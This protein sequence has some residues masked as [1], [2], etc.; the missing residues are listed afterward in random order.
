MRVVAYYWLSTNPQDSGLADVD[1]QRALA[2]AH[3]KANNGEV[4][5]EYLEMVSGQRRT[6][7][8][9]AEAIAHTQQVQGRLV[10]ANL[11][12]LVHS[13]T[14]TALLR[15]TGVDFVCGD[16]RLANRH[17]I[18]IL[19]AVA[20]DKTKRISTR[21]RAGLSA[22]KERG[23]KLGS[24]RE[25][26]WEGREERRRAGA[27]KG[28]A[29]AIPAAAKARTKKAQ[30]AYRELMPRIVAMREGELLSMA[31]IARRLNAEGHQTTAAR[32]FTATMILRLLKRASTSNPQPPAPPLVPLAAFSEMLLFRPSHEMAVA[33][34]T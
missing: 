34:E 17:T 12:R 28:L 3:A 18:H 29:V 22:A 15:D 1:A 10:V 6:W 13:T 31:E 23:V 26:H 30:E 8:K 33:G 16:N 11:D 25:G 24:A 2:A 4:V 9:L 7:P 19:A 20:S 14:F 21:T 32:P 5:A 27:R